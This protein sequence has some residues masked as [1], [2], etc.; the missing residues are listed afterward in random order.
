MD[1]YETFWATL[2]FAV[3]A[4]L[5]LYLIPKFALRRFKFS[6]KDTKAAGLNREQGRRFLASKRRKR[7]SGRV[8]F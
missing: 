4:A 7:K 6:K 1:R 2:A 5:V 3:L 8:R